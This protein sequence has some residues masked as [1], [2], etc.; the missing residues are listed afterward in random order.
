MDSIIEYVPG[1]I[2]PD[3]FVIGAGLDCDESNRELPYV[4]IFNCD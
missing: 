4:A 2:I 3:K 1:F